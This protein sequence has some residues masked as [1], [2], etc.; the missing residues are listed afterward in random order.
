MKMIFKQSKFIVI[1]SVVICLLLPIA[2]PILVMADSTVAT[3]IVQDKEFELSTAPYTNELGVMV[4]V[5]DVAR[6]FSY[7]YRFDSENKLFEIFADGYGKVTLMHNATEFFSGSSKFECLPYFYV[8]NGIPMIEIGFFCEMFNSSYEYDGQNLITI[9]KDIPKADI[10]ELD[11]T[12]QTMLMST[13]TSTCQ[14]SGK[15]Q[16]PYEFEHLSNVNVQLVV[17]PCSGPT[18][19]WETTYGGGGHYVTKILTGTPAELGEVVLQNGNNKSNFDY[20]L[21]ES[22]KNTNYPYYALSYAVTKDD[23]RKLKQYGAYKDNSE[24]IEL[25]SSPKNGAFSYN[26]HRYEITTQRSESIINIPLVGDN[27]PNTSDEYYSKN[28]AYHFSIRDYEKSNY[29]DENIFNITIGDEKWTT[30]KGGMVSV[31]PEKLSGDFTVDAEGYMPLKLSTDYLKKYFYNRFT[32]YKTG[33]SKKAE[34]HAVYCGSKNVFNTEESQVFYI[35]DTTETT[36]I[37]PV[38]NT[39]GKKIKKVKIVQGTTEVPIE[40]LDYKDAGNINGKQ[41]Q[42]VTGTTGRFTP[43][44]KFGQKNEPIYIVVTNT[45]G[46]TT[47]HKL[48]I[49]L[50]EKKQNDVNLDLGEEVSFESPDTEDNILGSMS[51]KYKLFDKAPFSFKMTPDGKGN[52]GIKGTIGLDSLESKQESKSYETVKDAFKS[53]ARESYMDGKYDGKNAIQKFNNYFKK[54]GDAGLTSSDRLP[55]AEMGI[56]CNLKMYGYVDGS[57]DLQPDD[58]YKLNFSEGGISAKFDFGKDV[59]RQTFITTPAGPVPVYWTAGLE[60]ADALTIPLVGE[61]GKLTIPDSVDNEF[62]M[63]I[64]GGGGIGITDL[65]TCGA[66]GEGKLAITC[67]IPLSKDTLE[68]VVSGKINLF[69]FELGI[70]QGTLFQ[71]NT[72]KLML[73]PEFHVIPKNQSMTTLEPQQLSRAYVD[74]DLVFNME[75][76]QP[77][78]LDDSGK[79]ISTS[80]V[81]TNTY[82][83][84]NPQLIE[85]SEGNL[86]LVWIEDERSRE[87]AADRTAIYYSCYANGVWTEP[88]IVYDDTTADFNPKLKKINNKVYLTWA[89]AT[90]NFDANESDSA[91]IAQTLVTSA[92]VWNGKEFDLLGALN[93][94]GAIVSD[95]TEIDGVPT[96]VWTENATGDLRQTE[97]NN[98]LKSARLVGS[99]WNVN[100]L[101]DN[102]AAIDGLCLTENNGSLCVYYSQDTDGDTTTIADKEIFAFSN[103]KITQIT[104]NE[105]ADTKPIVVNNV[106]YWYS[107]SKIAY[108]DVYGENVDYIDSGCL[109][110]RFKVSD[111]GKKKSI[112]FSS[113]NDNGEQTIVAICNDGE[114]WGK[115]IE[116]CASSNLIGG[117]DSTYCSD[118]LLRVVSNDVLIQDDTFG[119]AT[120]K[121]YEMSDYYDIAIDNLSYDEYSVNDDELW[122][123]YDV[124]NN[125]T[126]TVKELETVFYDE[127]NS[128]LSTSYED[129]VLL[130]GETI[131]LSTACYRHQGKSLKVTVTPWL[132]NGGD[133]NLDDNTAEIP[134]YKSDISIEKM[135]FENTGDN[136]IISGFVFNRGVDDVSDVSISLRKN[137]S[138]GDVIDT[139]T[140]SVIK[141]GEFEYVEFKLS[142]PEDGLYYMTCDELENENLIGNNTDFLKYSKAALVMKGDILADGVV[143]SKDAVRLAQYLAKWDITLTPDEMKAA[144][145]VTDGVINSKDAVKLAQYLAKWDVTLD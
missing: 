130:P 124:T 28:T 8:E 108:K 131:T 56:K 47:K 104:D 92:A 90:K 26:A 12:P 64:K 42:I 37:I 55:S 78:G 89:N 53:A 96:I 116:V 38:I 20:D 126:S 48:N 84:S 24:T 98:I 14:V 71:I 75:A 118:G 107:D 103:G 54:I 49:K 35:G 65:A 112:V 144:D 50:A 59:V 73:Y 110:D 23:S 11:Y 30:G 143:N 129:V 9:Y 16:L 32:M 113:Y 44:V 140:T 133:S 86:L 36:E 69:D 40:K 109:S 21:P 43:G 52:Y 134:I 87:S 128:R 95:I 60:F 5:E 7:G 127:N 33:Y 2:M 94:N 25:G 81:A 1:W 85:I 70:L 145:I 79:S 22:V 93:N 51:L 61:D 58:T 66:S 17:T 120:I 67:T 101:L 142:E 138:T 91:K 45:F 39:N 6:A 137:T 31:K 10:N 123:Y 100:K 41:Y 132:R 97:K 62:E 117:Y 3:I 13:N 114:G 83:F 88:K 18:S 105:V 106:L 119:K 125:G 4:N 27:K 74:E 82:T 76:V 139:I 136:T 15:V 121:L 99:E 57:Y 135:S 29:Y 102:Q 46:E 111:N 34:I 115:P 19:V 72:P 122:V 141:P 77:M 63:A 80:T 68:A